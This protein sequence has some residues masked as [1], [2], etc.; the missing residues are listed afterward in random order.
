MDNVAISI[1]I[2]RDVYAQLYKRKGLGEIKHLQTFIIK[3]IE[4]KLERNNLGKEE[5]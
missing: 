5:G 2:P 1:R 4:E 3:A